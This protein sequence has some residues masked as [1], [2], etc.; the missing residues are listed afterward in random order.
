[1][2]VVVKRPE[3]RS[4]DHD[5]ISKMEKEQIEESRHRY[6][7]PAQREQKQVEETDD[8]PMQGRR[9]YYRKPKSDKNASVETDH[10]YKKMELDDKH[11]RLFRK[12]E[13][14]HR[15]FMSVWL[16]PRTSNGG[17]A[18]PK[19]SLLDTPEHLL[20]LRRIAKRS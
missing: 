18:K 6:E 1:M 7:A 19:R 2:P 10:S 3:S 14:S 8:G 9:S 13:D 20:M 4:K 11:I 15:M 17:S 5:R 16:P 12:A